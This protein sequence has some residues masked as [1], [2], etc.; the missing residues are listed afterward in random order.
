[1]RGDPPLCPPFLCQK[2]GVE[3]AGDGGLGEASAIYW[4]SSRCM[5]L[6]KSTVLLGST[7]ATY[8]LDRIRS[9]KAKHGLDDSGRVVEKP[10]QHGARRR[11]G[12]CAEI[13]VSGL[14]PPPTWP[15]LH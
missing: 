10:K 3:L 2:P 1:M 11:S 7:L 15:L 13:V 9:F 12:T 6:I 14:A 4:R 8:D 5:G